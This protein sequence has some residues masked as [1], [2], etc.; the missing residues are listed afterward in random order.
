MLPRYLSVESSRNPATP[1]LPVDLVLFRQA[2][3][4]TPKEIQFPSSE[5]IAARLQRIRDMLG[6]EGR[7]SSRKDVEQADENTPPFIAIC[8]DNIEAIRSG[9]IT[10]QHGRLSSVS[11]NTINLSD[12]TSLGDI[13]A[14]ILATG[15]QASFDFFD[16]STLT[17]LSY[18][19]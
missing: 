11:G 2:P 3:R 9:K 10:I 17:Q 12:G 8:D 5:S 1:F 15:L 14:L 7:I 18:K 4:P 13:E 19:K 16:P 6:E